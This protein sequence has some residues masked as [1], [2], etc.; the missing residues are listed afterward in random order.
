MAVI[1][2]STIIAAISPDEQADDARRLL[3]VV[4]AGT[5]STPALMLYECANTLHVKYRRG[6][7]DRATRDELLDILA[8]FPL[9]IVGPDHGRM[10]SMIVP[11]AERHG[12]SVYDAAY[13]DLARQRVVP[14]ATRDRR[15]R[16]AAQAEQVSVL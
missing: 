14:L 4:F 6:I 7:F 12:I 13:L 3:D 11:L 16:A 10:T 8:S 1:D 15:L 2:A 5:A 9:E